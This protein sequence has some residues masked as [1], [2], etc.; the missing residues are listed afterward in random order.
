MVGRSDMYGQYKVHIRT[1]KNY[2]FCPLMRA[3]A[4]RGEGKR[5]C[6][7]KGEEWTAIPGGSV[8]DSEEL[9]PHVNQKSLPIYTLLVPKITVFLFSPSSV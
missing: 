3:K 2:Y 6:R 7:G 4:W 5:V 8:E 1:Q 9:H